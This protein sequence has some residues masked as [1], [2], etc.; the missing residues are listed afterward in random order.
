MLTVPWR[1]L[2]LLALSGFACRSH[3]AQT[4]GDRRTLA[5]RHRSMLNDRLPIP[6][7]ELPDELQE[8]IRTNPTL[9]VGCR[10]Y[11]VQPIL[12]GKDRVELTAR[13][14]ALVGRPHTLSWLWHGTTL[15]AAER[16]L[17]EGP[18]NAQISHGRWNGPGF[19]MATTPGYAS[20][21]VDCDGPRVLLACHTLIGNRLITHSESPP[22]FGSALIRSAGNALGTHIVKPWVY[23]H[24]DVNVAFVV[25]LG[26][27][28]MDAP[29]SPPPTEP[30]EDQ[31][32]CV[33]LG[34]TIGHT[35]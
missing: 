21:Y 10:V 22:H 24:T 30:E 29:R 25:V 4:E 1:R 26:I 3:L 31:E 20:R 28:D 8:Q 11:D 15:Y 6:I 14:E 27:E 12:H 5:Y 13:L 2:P 33:C 7:Q 17:Q 16:I 35:K 23:A 34:P 18:Q 32:E 9:F 19:Y